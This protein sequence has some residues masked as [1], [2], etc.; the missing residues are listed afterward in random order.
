MPSQSLAERVGANVRAE[1]ARQKTTQAA[2]AERLAMKQQALSRRISGRT[3]F[4]VDELHRVAKALGVS[5]SALMVDTP[6]RA[7]SA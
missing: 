4:N 1:M 6:S 2:L 5:T 3:P 7:A